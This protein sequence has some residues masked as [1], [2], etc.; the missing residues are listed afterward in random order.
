MTSKSSKNQFHHLTSHVDIIHSCYY[1][2]VP[3][4]DEINFCSFSTTLMYILALRHP[5][6]KSP[7]GTLHGATKHVN[8][9]RSLTWAR[10]RE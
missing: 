5:S 10:D 1:V 7:K 9:C 6:F 8:Q 4:S 2:Y 3:Y